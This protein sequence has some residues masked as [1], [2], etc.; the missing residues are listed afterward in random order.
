MRQRCADVAPAPA[1][2]AGQRLVTTQL[3]EPVLGLVIGQVLRGLVLC[4]G[5]GCAAQPREQLRPDRVQQVL[6]GR[7]ELVDDGQRRQR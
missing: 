1:L 5:F 6:A 4:G 3:H 7:A 2:A